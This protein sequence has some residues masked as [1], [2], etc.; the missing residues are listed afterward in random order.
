MY[1]HASRFQ[2]AALEEINA[3][4]AR[5]KDRKNVCGRCNKRKLAGT[6]LQTCSRCK[7]INYCSENCQQEH[8]RA[9][10]KREC[11]KFMQ[12]PLAKTFDPSDRL[13]VPWPVD[14]IFAKSNQ[15]GVGIWMAT[16]GRLGTLL[17][18]AFEPAEG[19]GPDCDFS[20]GPPSYQS[21]A[22]L[23]DMQ[24]HGKGVEARKYIG[25]TLVTL[26]I[27]VQ[28]RRTDGRVVAVYG[29]NTVYGVYDHLKGCLL[30][31]ELARV[32]YHT[33]EEDKQIVF[34]PPWIDYNGKLRV[35]IAE[36][37]GFVAPKGRFAP[38]GEYQPAA[39][40]TGTPW[41]RVADWEKAQVVLGPGDFA[42][43]R[44]QYRLGDGHKYDAYPEIISRCPVVSLPCLL[45]TAKITDH[46][47]CDAALGQLQLAPHEPVVWN[48]FIDLYAEMDFEYAEEY[49]K[50]YFEESTPAFMAQ[51]HGKRA[52]YGN[53]YFKA[54]SS[55]IPQL[56]EMQEGMSPIERNYMNR[57]TR[58][59]GIGYAEMI[60]RA[61]DS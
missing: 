44:V 33:I 45:T 25:F 6:R 51:R 12:P 18:R 13:D 15:N 57:I 19:V 22:G 39:R 21:W 58:D 48:N 37:N 4:K 23:P 28:N 40:P 41:D 60:M 31:E 61:K 32:E 35:A 29:D 8:W 11:A 49:F 24:K 42:V 20:N 27:V 38:G 9:G 55:T 46:D 56:G 36:I 54:G 30:P 26:R 14:P 59:V 50:P 16:G 10:H 43:F 17:Q 1:A 53:E 5:R 3:R 52:E 34:N 47:W 2:V 7:S